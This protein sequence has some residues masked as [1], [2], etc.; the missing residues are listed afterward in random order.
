MTSDVLDLIHLSQ[1]IPTTVM[2]G[3]KSEIAGPFRQGLIQSFFTGNVD[4][5]DTANITLHNDGRVAFEKSM[6][7]ALSIYI[8]PINY[9]K[10]IQDIVNETS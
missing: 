9:P 3:I 5:R 10:L 7:D 6:R 2:W 4:P 1:N 8:T